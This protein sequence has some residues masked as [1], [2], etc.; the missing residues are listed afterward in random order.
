MTRVWVCNR[1]TWDGEGPNTNAP[2]IAARQECLGIYTDEAKARARC[3]IA[4]RDFIAPLELDVD[5]PE[6]L[7]PWP[8]AYY[9]L[10]QDRPGGPRKEGT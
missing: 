2:T 8:E 3:R 5:Q 7:I 10:L 9:P 1:V 6:D 4:D